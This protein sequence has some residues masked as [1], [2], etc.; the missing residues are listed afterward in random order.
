MGL[1]TATTIAGLNA[2]WPLGTDP[3][4]QGDDHLR[5]IKSV[6][7]NDALSKAA[8]GTVQGPLT[9]MGILT[10]ADL[11][12][13]P[14]PGFRAYNYDGATLQM[15][16]QISD[17]VA[18]QIIFGTG[19]APVVA[20]GG[21]V[22]FRS[23]GHTSIDKV[24]ITSIAR[25]SLESPNFRATGAW[26]ATNAAAAN[27][28]VLS[29]GS[30]VRSTSSGRFKDMVK[31]LAG[32][33]ATAT[34]MALRPVSY[35]ALNEEEPRRRA[36]FIA[37]EVAEVLPEAEEVENYDHRAILAHVVAA[38]QAAIERIAVLEA[39]AG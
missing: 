36:G 6:L 2:N 22:I 13:A 32:S 9:T 21:R 28:V 19:N 3:K 1:E 20:A 33:A 26:S 27:L 35:R 15:G 34:V 16:T 31:A 10:G 24:A 14:N 23:T 37:E 5:L 7:Q 18:G 11:R 8:G 12:L 17:T 4:S 39:R 38:L 25:I 30:I 29:D